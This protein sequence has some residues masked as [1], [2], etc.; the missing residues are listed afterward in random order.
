MEFNYKNV[1]IYSLGIVVIAFGVV[2]MLKSD[3]GLSS[4]DTLHYSIH[5]LTGMTVGT[6]VILVA[7]LF[8]AYVTTANWHLKYLLM[9]IPIL[10]VGALIDYFN[11]ILFIDFEPSN[12]IIQILIYVLGLFMLPLGGTLL[13]ISTFPAGVFDEF[14][15][16]LMRQF[17]SDNLI[18]VRVIMELC[19]VTVA[20]GISLI[21]ADP[22][23][24]VGM[25]NVGTIIFSVTV[26]VMV[27]AYLSLFETIGL[28]KPKKIDN[29]L[30]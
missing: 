16:I 4:W 17:K 30:I 2:M 15:L 7:L 13:I 26:G 3:V 12:L 5:R 23:E 9:V 14:M 8:T 10:I 27:K 24:P 19:A 25:F 18:K 20:I 22:S 6:A 21:V 28:Y 11:L 1:I 29:S